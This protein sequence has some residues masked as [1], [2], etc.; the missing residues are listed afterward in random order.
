MY[1]LSSRQ[2]TLFPYLTPSVET[3]VETV[4]FSDHQE[5]V[6]FAGIFV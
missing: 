5:I 3:I 6:E 4:R 1:C 2:T